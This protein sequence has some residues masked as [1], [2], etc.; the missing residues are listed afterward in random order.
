MIRYLF[1][2]EFT[3]KP[4]DLVLVLSMSTFHKSISHFRT[5]YHCYCEDGFTGTH[6]QTDWD[7]CWSAPCANGA[8]CVD[9]VADFNCTCTPGFR[10]QS[11]QGDHSGR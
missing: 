1:Q 3:K 7:E 9:L 11:K 2:D 4:L 10:G 5:G 8:T 6:C